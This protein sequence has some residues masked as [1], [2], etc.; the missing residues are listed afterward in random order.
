MKDG[1]PNMFIFGK[2]EEDCVCVSLACPSPGLWVLVSVACECRVMNSV[3]FD[4]GKANRYSDLY[5]VRLGNSEGFSQ[6]AQ[7]MLRLGHSGL[8]VVAFTFT[9]RNS[10]FSHLFEPRTRD[11]EES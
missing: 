1:R 9:P 2:R 4:G 8:M 6:A 5:E 11:Q 7:D 10:I 3:S